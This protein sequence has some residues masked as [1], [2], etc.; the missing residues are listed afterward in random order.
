MLV[1]HTTQA[2][3]ALADHLD[4][5]AALEFDLVH[6]GLRVRGCGRPWPG[7]GSKFVSEQF[8]RAEQMPKGDMD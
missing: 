2:V 8:F 7:W 5:V 3:F 1:A 4:F 6:F